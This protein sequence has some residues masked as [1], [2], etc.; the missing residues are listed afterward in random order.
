MTSTCTYVFQQGSK[1]GETCD[2]TCRGD[3]CFKH[4]PKVFEYK[5]KYYREQRLT[6]GEAECDEIRKSIEKGDIPDHNKYGLKRLEI[7]CEMKILL[8]QIYGI[9]LVLGDITL[10]ELE[11]KLDKLMNESF[12]RKMNKAINKY[13]ELTNNERKR[14]EEEYMTEY[15]NFRQLCYTP[16]RGNYKRAKST[17]NKLRT[18]YS[19]LLEKLK[20]ATKICKIINAA[21][22]NQLKEDVVEV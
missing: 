4:K 6:K 14:K 5:K 17:L 13:G 19:V 18:E 9:L 2:A 7:I 10:E 12:Y 15:A 22:D 3:F 21:Y 8:K 20:Q 1:K 11:K 16:Y